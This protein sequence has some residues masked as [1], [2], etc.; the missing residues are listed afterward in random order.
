VVGFVGG[1]AAAA[2]RRNRVERE[3]DVKERK[4]GFLAAH[5]KVS[6]FYYILVLLQFRRRD[7]HVSM[8]GGVECS[9]MRFS[10]PKRSGKKF[11][12]KAQTLKPGYHFTGS[13]G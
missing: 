4:P 11:S 9:I 13:K 8:L 5:P 12:L 2:V 6:R 10:V 7:G 1:V 3:R